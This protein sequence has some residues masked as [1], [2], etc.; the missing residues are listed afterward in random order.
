MKK[1]SLLVFGFLLLIP[2]DAQDL[3]GLRSGKTIEAKIINVDKDRIR[4]IPDNDPLY[5]HTVN[6]SDVLMIKYES[7]KVER[8]S[9]PQPYGNMSIAE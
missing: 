4:Y 9:I 7:G 3:I 8:F 2:M 5:E 6:I 1:L